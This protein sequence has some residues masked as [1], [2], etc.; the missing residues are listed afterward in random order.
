MQCGKTEY[1]YI[2]CLHICKTIQIY[3]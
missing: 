3:T 2:L 1:I